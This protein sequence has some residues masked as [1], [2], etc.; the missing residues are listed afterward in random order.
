L[1]S[2]KV[3]ILGYHRVL[4]AISTEFGV[5]DLM[6]CAADFR[7]QLSQFGKSREWI[8]FEDLPDVGPRDRVSILTFDDGY[9]D[10][11]SIAAPIL[12]ELGIRATFFVTTG[13]VAG[14]HFPWWE[15]TYREFINIGEHVGPAWSRH[16]SQFIKNPPL[17]SANPSGVDFMSWDQLR[18]LV[19]RGHQ[20]QAHTVSHPS[21]AHCEENIEIR[22]S[23]AQVREE[24]GQ[25]PFVFAY[26]YGQQD[27]FGERET[28]QLKELGY[29]YAVSTRASSG[30]DFALPRLMV[31]AK[32]TPLRL[33]LKEARLGFLENSSKT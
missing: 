28:R 33:R 17:V 8:Q 23:T 12:D 14:T 21:L 26:P 20:V 6:V 1:L 24:L 22:E 7:A 13:F 10:N 30:G 15:S 31:G 11:F 32:D 29:R 9:V 2:P 5:P 16:R 4:P 19:S 18:E 27:N 3:L 25:D